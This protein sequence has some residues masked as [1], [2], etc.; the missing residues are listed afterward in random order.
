MGVVY[1]AE[2]H[3]TRDFVKRVAIKVIRQSYANQKIFDEGFLVGVTL[4]ND[5]DR[6]AFDE[7]ARAVLFRF[8]NDAHAA[9]KNLAND[10]VAELGLNREQAAHASMLWQWNVKSSLRSDGRIS[11]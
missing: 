5:F 7:V 11:I 2:Q 1:E 3:G 8:V 4:A 6:H 10:L 9:F